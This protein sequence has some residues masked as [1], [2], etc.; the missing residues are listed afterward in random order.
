MFL[1]LKSSLGPS[2]SIFSLENNQ[3]HHNG[4]QTYGG[5]NKG[6]DDAGIWVPQCLCGAILK[7]G[8]VDIHKYAFNKVIRPGKQQTFSNSLSTHSEIVVCTARDRKKESHQLLSS[9]Y[10]I[11][12]HLITNPWKI[13]YLFTLSK[14]HQTVLFMDSIAKSK[15]YLH[16]STTSSSQHVLKERFT[17]YEQYML[18]TLL[19]PQPV[20]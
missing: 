6:K 20:M 3:D 12:W 4:D 15:L 11:I 17:Q 18:Q 9:T 19:L 14:E 2:V 13:A 7:I 16:Q 8:G 10:S 1:H 5:H